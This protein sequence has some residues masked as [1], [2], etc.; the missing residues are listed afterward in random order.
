DPTVLQTTVWLLYLIPVMALFFLLP[1]GG[2]KKKTP[3]PAPAAPG[4]TSV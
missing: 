1:K 2:P 3:A 4:T